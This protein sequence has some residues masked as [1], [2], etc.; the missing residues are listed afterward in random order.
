MVVIAFLVPLAVL[1]QALAQERALR[2]AE[3][4]AQSLAPALALEDD[5]EVV[6]AF[7]ASAQA[8][9]DGTLTVFLPDGSTL[10]TATPMDSHVLAARAG[11]AFTADE[12]TGKEIY[13]PVF[14]SGEDDVAVVRA[15]VPTRV[16]RR[17]VT[18]AW[19]GLAA[20]GVVLIA[21]AGFVADRLGRSTVRAVR[22]LESVANRLAAGD[23]RA[24]AQAPEPE[25][26]VRVAGA[27][28]L[29]ANRI[30]ELLAEEREAAANLSH[31]LRTPL[32]TLRLDAEALPSAPSADRIRAG[33]DDLERAVDRVI[34][35]A[36]RP[37]REGV[38]ASTDLVDVVRD[39]AAFWAALADEQGR[40]WHLDVDTD[41]APV[42][43]LPDDAE[44]VVDALLGNVFA[45][46][47]DAVAF[48]IGLHRVADD[49]VELVVED[50]GPG[51]EAGALERGVSGAASTGLGLDIVRRTAELTGG[52]VEV[53][54]S[55]LGGACVRVA[56]RAVRPQ[57]RASTGDVARTS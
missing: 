41:R 13:V 57:A 2:S 10:G 26:V 6:D 25:E 53:G 18:T 19:V 12:P 32:T 28:N 5:P 8:R 16:V 49:V 33:V 54:R 1:V 51:I 17:G 11:A 7:V 24:R 35:D 29:L 42:P 39:R 3:V 52:G 23:L 9:V 31:R 34:R 50:G 21:G 46:T 38:G 20:L 43:V 37:L 27:L 40:P 36:R 47:P 48:R 22:E 55:P 14:L 30:V 56:F 45:H 44:A 4:A 15:F